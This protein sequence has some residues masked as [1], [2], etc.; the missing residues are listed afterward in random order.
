MKDLDCS[1]ISLFIVE[2]VDGYKNTRLFES[3]KE[4]THTVDIDQYQPW[5]LVDLGEEER[6]TH[7]AITNRGDCCRKI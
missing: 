1:H 3:G 5:W 7:V 6:V 4:C 2:A